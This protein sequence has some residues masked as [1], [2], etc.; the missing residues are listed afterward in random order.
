[1]V[2]VPGVIPATT[3]VDE[4]TEP[5][6]VLLLLHVPPASTSDNAVLIP[7]QAFSVPVMVAGSGLMVTTAVL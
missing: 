7:G 5:I 3:P 1:M 2:V 4:P 6:A